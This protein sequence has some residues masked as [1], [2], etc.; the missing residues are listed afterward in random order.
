MRIN[1]LA[2][3][4][5]ILAQAARRRLKINSEK[6]PKHIHPQENK[7]KYYYY[8]FGGHWKNKNWKKKKKITNQSKQLRERLQVKWLLNFSNENIPSSEASKKYDK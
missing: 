7:L 5:L 6:D 4:R 3:L 1:V 2:R 8:H